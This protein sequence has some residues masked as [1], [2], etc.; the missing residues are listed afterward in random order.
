MCILKIFVR[1]IWSVSGKLVVSKTEIIGF[2]QGF[3]EQIKEMPT[4]E[5]SFFLSLSRIL[6]HLKTA[7]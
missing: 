4:K 6:L 1:Q 3:A 5:K 2:N 7:T